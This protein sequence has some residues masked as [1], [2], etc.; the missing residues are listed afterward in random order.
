MAIR[1]A[2]VNPNQDADSVKV[3]RSLNKI[4]LSALPEPLATLPGTATSYSDAT[5]ARNTVY[6]Y[7]VAITRGTDT[8]YTQNQQYGY[9]PDTGPGSSKLL[10]GNWKEGYFGTCTQNELFGALELCTALNVSLAVQTANP[11]VWH[12]FILDGKILFIPSVSIASV[13]LY[14]LY[15]AGLM[16]GTDDAGVR[17]ATGTISTR[18]PKNQK[19]LVT[20]SDRQYL[21]RLPKASTAPTSEFLTDLTTADGRWSEG[22]WNRT[23]GRLGF[24][25]F[26][27]CTRTRWGRL[28]VVTSNNTAATLAY[29]QHHN[30]AG[31]AVVMAYIAAGWDAP[32]NGLGV[33]SNYYGWKPVLELVL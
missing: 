21:V 26:T 12:K 32:N 31:N 2:I 28:P 27:F 8:L 20:K 19:T 30:G 33:T 4:Q 6:N 25:N 13:A 14:S 9:F 24:T 1:I 3:Y 7:M 15:D 29:T 22:E 5:A 18:T 11:I 17:P 16:Y 10:R 23:M